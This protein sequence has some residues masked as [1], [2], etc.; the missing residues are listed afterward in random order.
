M[1]DPISILRGLA[2]QPT[3]L[4]RAPAGTPNDG[5]APIDDRKRIYTGRV[6]FVWAFYA[7]MSCAEFYNW[8]SLELQLWRL[9]ARVARRSSTV[10]GKSSAYQRG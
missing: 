7:A 9:T 1:H 3:A 6:R 10:R 8:L 4:I 2:Y 5:K